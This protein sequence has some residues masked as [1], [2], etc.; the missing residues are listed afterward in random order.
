[1]IQWEDPGSWHLDKKADPD[2]GVN[3]DTQAH[4]FAAPPHTKKPALRP[5]VVMDIKMVLDLQVSMHC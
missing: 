1:M 4:L 3:G 5:V 2:V